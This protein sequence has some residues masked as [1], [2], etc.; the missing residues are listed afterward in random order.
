MT[1][2]QLDKHLN[3]VKAYHRKRRAAERSLIPL[4]VELPSITIADEL[5]EAFIRVV[6]ELAGD[7]NNWID[8]YIYENDFGKKKHE[9]GYDGNRKPIK[10]TRQLLDL[11]NEGR[12]Q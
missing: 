7:R 1:R 12:R 6:S 8:W 9:A 5:E 10:T 2:K 11:I 4:T 3:V